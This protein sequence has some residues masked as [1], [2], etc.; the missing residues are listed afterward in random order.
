VSIHLFSPNNCGRQW[1][2]LQDNWLD[3]TRQ[4]QVPIYTYR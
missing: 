4:K 2:L 3:Q 1:H